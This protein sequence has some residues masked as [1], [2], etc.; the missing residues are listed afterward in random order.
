MENIVK[1]NIGEED[2][3]PTINETSFYSLIEES[4]IGDSNYTKIPMSRLAAMGTAFQPVVTA[5]Q[6]TV[7]GAGGERD[8][9]CGYRWKI[10]V[11][12]ERC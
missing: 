10:N 12:N 11:S 4:K 2:V 5:I 3:Q 7:N 9:F 6:T 1:T 8:L